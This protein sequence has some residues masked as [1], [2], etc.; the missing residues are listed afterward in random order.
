M[1]TTSLRLVAS[2]SSV[3]LTD[4]LPLTFTTWDFIPTYE[5]PNLLLLL[6]SLRVKLPSISV[7]VPLLVT[8]CSTTVAPITGSPVLSFTEPVMVWAVIVPDA[9]RRNRDSSAIR[10]LFK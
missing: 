2:S 10:M 9:T 3:M 8:P 6:L 4:F 5:I 7:T 1:T